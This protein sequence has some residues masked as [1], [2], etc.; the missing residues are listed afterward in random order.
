MCEQN[1]EIVRRGYAMFSAGDIEGAAEMFAEDTEIPGAGGLGVPDSTDGPR[2]GPEG[3]LRSVADTQAAFEDYRVKT[4]ELI[5]VSDAVVVP[6]RIRGRERDNGARLEMCSA[7][8]W[9]LRDGVVVQGEVNR[10]AEEALQ[11]A[12]LL[13]LA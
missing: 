12:R 6:V 8:L 10:T 5:A 2:I 3:F 13:T 11:A 9:V 7:H 1:V 4:D